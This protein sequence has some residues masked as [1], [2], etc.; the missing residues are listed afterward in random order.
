MSSKNYSPIKAGL[1]QGFGLPGV[2]M[3]S[4]MLGFGALAYETGL[5]IFVGL[6]SMLFL[7]SMPA[8][9][10]FATLIISGSSFFLMFFTILLANVRTLFMVLSAALIMDFKNKNAPFLE[11]L[12]WAQW[13][14]PTGW[15]IISANI[16][17]IK[18]EDL[19]SYFKGI[20]V[21]LVS[22]CTIGLS[23]GYFCLDEIPK[24][25]IS[26]PI[27]FIPLW[28]IILMLHAKGI[29]YK[30]S[31]FSS[32]LYLFFLY[33]YIENLSII[34]AGFLSACTGYIVERLLKK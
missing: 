2:G 34:L 13:V 9:L 6:L 24:I 19:F 21:G 10:I 20:S 7:W 14:S 8:M 15:T 17:K 29:F 4:A 18:K 22:M 12:F 5:D 30:T 16:D 33:P 1:K 11:K 32:C 28:L 25:L 23:I 26:I 27:F 31:I 3:G